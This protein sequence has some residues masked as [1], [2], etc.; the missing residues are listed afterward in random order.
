[1]SFPRIAD[2]PVIAYDLET[3]G[4]TWWQ[5]KIFGVALSTPEQDHYWDV[6]REP[7]VIDW[8]REEMPR[9]RKVVNHHIKFDWHFSREAGIILPNDRT[10]CTMIRAALIDEHRLTYD[11]DSVAKDC[12]GIGKDSSIYQELADLFGGKPTRHA[13]MPNLPRAP[14]SIVGRYAKQDTRA[15]L[16]LWMW[17]QEQ[18]EKQ[19]LE[20]VHELE[21]QLLPVI[22]RMEQYGVRVDI[23][24][25]ERAAN[26]LDVKVRQ[27]QRELDRLAG[28]PVNPNPSGSIHKL[29][30]PREERTADGTKIFVL[31]DGTI[32]DP[33]DSGAKASID[34]DCLRRMKHPA[35]AKI[36]GLRKMIKARDTFL[37]GHVLGNHHGGLIH[38]NINQT[39]SEGDVGTG[40]GRLSVNAPALQQIPKRDKDMAAIVRAVFVPYQGCRWVCNDWAQMDFRVFSHYVR[41]AEILEM[42]NKDPD[43]DF[44]SLAAGLTG[45]PRSAR[46]A[47][48]PNAKQINLG[49]VFGMG[50]GKLAQ[51]M[52]LPF[53]IEPN[54]R[55][56]TW[57]KPGPEAEAVFEK[58][59]ANIPGVRDLLKDASAVA[60]S[61]G[62][63]C[64]ILGRRIRFPRG[65][66]VY[67]AGGLIFQ[68]TAADALKVKLVEADQFFES[69]PDHIREAGARLVLNVHD[70]FD[71]MLPEGCDHLKDEVNRIL[72]AFGPEDRISLRVPIR[73]D[74]GVGENW[75]IASA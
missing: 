73:T 48:D 20:R 42:Y 63:V 4:L 58:Y 49:L 36:L 2:Y 52:G 33:S 65:M 64:T 53:T 54:G 45:L 37:R 38:A 21:M 56:G 43:T 11:L 50:Q 66:F 35:A 9:V 41:N 69:Q 7:E 62:H 68:G 14:A 13:Q 5:D 75:H 17:Q 32:A 3:T 29:F 28:F 10:E 71:W 30:E 8:L 57:V 47:G 25:A 46:F 1:V 12:V 27:E 31:N 40:T 24:A 16:R 51:E 6:R 39:K 34:A 67:K 61:R 44:H 19:G 15:A 74:Q 59:H 18:I 23:G 26:A 55:G 70:E 60:K 22:V 72:T